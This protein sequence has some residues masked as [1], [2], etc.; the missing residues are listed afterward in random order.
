MGLRMLCP[1]ETRLTSSGDLLKM[2][3]RRMHQAEQK[4]SFLA[5]LSGGLEISRGFSSTLASHKWLLRHGETTQLL[6][7]VI[8]IFEQNWYL[9]QCIDFIISS[10]YRLEDQ[11]LALFLWIK[12]RLSLCSR[13]QTNIPQILRAATV[14]ISALKSTEVQISRHD[15]WQQAKMPGRFLPNAWRT[16]GG[17][18]SFA[19]Q[20]KHQTKTKPAL[21]TASLLALAPVMTNR[22][23]SAASLLICCLEKRE[24]EVQ[25]REVSN[26]VLGRMLVI[27]VVGVEG[28][29]T[30]QR[31]L[32]LEQLSAKVMGYYRWLIQQAHVLW[33]FIRIHSPPSSF[34][35]SLKFHLNSHHFG[36]NS[37][38][39]NLKLT[40]SSHQADRT[41]HKQLW[42][43]PPGQSE[44]S[45]TPLPH[46]RR[47]PKIQNTLRNPP[48]HPAFA[49]KPADRLPDSSKDSPVVLS[50]EST[51]STLDSWARLETPRSCFSTTRLD[52]H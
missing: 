12:V 25:L 27:V 13:V 29:K 18:G 40:T 36:Q 1:W 49:H 32:I 30:P 16:E 22:A 26:L 11:S 14:D 44:K 23:E 43:P 3:V 48:P 15:S 9:D 10:C 21:N 17:L 50:F 2:E 42:Q 33:F 41:P 35:T 37:A 46:L 5:I 6:S 45:P 52:A 38:D 34:S 39:H 28:G 24:V 4:R 19:T 51:C 8:Q 47:D 31:K 7:A 20:N